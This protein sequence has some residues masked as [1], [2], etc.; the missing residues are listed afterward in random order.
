MYSILLTTHSIFRW[1]VLAS[2]IYAL[3][4]SYHG[5]LKKSSY[6]NFDDRIRHTTATI[7]HI[8]FV[9]GLWLY[10]VSP[11]VDYFLKNFQGA[12]HQRDVRF[13]AMEHSTMMFIAVIVISIGSSMA[14][15]R[16][17]DQKKFKTIAIWFT[18]GLIIILLSIPWGFSPFTSR[19][20]FR[21]F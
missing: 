3:Y 9:I 11:I 10:F 17:T 5:L 13:F 19:P 6:T 2:L 8:Q 20:Y 4:R 16:Q 14:K 15:R 21:T 1:L 12:I 7:L 18:I